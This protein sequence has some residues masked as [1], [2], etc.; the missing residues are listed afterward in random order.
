M[1]KIAAAQ[2]PHEMY[3]FA[4]TLSFTRPQVSRVLGFPC[5]K[6]CAEDVCAFDSGRRRFF[7]KKSFSRAVY[8][9]TG[10]YKHF[11]GSHCS[12]RSIFLAGVFRALVVSRTSSKS[13]PLWPVY[14]LKVYVFFINSNAFWRD[15]L[16]LIFT[17][18]KLI[19]WNYCFLQL[20][21]P[22]H[23]DS[24]FDHQPWK[25]RSWGHHDGAWLVWRVSWQVWRFSSQVTGAIMSRAFF[26][27][28]LSI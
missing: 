9:C 4:P 25:T 12:C 10:W 11:V 5:I 2:R 26:Q 8:P 7:W 6:I 18:T 19:P 23:D 28:A 17:V 1:K 21:I 13:L 15:Y 20:R 24:W 22:F 16:R 27:N 14:F 3:L